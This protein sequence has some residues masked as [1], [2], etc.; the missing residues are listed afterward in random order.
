VL[1]VVSLRNHVGSKRFRETIYGYILRSMY[2]HA[3]DIMWVHAKA[4]LKPFLR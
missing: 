1:S 2:G 4:T 3:D